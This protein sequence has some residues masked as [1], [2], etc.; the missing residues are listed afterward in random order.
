MSSTDFITLEH[1]DA[2]RVAWNAC[3]TPNE[4]DD[5]GLQFN[6]RMLFPKNSP[7]LPRLKALAQ[8]AKVAA[9][10]ENP[11]FKIE[12]PFKDGNEKYN[13]DPEKFAAY[14]DM[15][16]VSFNSKY[17]PTVFGADAKQINA[18]NQKDFYSGCWA[19]MHCNAYDWTYKNKQGQI[20]KRGISFGF[21]A[22]QKIRDDERLGGTGG[23]VQSAEQA[24]FSAA[25]SDSPENYQQP[26]ASGADDWL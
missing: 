23:G 17:Q 10:G 13:E 15:V 5:G 4:K 12:S 25:A 7:A 9:Y 16:V 21:D 24:G 14:K 22:V 20:M 6:V 3:F 8:Q 1:A 26:A 2:G 18:L 19:V 11:S